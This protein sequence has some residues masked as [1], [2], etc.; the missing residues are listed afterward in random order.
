MVGITITFAS[1]YRSRLSGHKFASNG[2]LPEIGAIPRRDRASLCKPRTAP[3]SGA[4]NNMVSKETVANSR[5]YGSRIPSWAIGTTMPIRYFSTVR[6]P[7]LMSAVTGMPGVR[8]KLVGTS[9]SAT[10][11]SDIRAR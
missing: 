6:F 7:T 10:R 1:R 5:S 9:W 4:S 3:L 8:W 2:L 11:S